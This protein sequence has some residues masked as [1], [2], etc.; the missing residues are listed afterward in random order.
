MIKKP[1]VAFA[2]LSCAG[3]S[4]HAHLIA[5]SMGY[6]YV[7]GSALLASLAGVASGRSSWR[8]NQSAIAAIRQ[9]DGA[10]QLVDETIRRRV[11]DGPPAVFDSWAL[12][13]LHDGRTRLITVL[14]KSSIRARG[15]RLRLELSRSSP[16][17]TQEEAEA[18]LVRKDAETAE[19]LNRIY[20]IDILDPPEDRFTICQDTSQLVSAP[21][22]EA[23][24]SS[25]SIVHRLLLTAI[26][27]EIQSL[28]EDETS[29]SIE[30]LAGCVVLNDAGR[31]LLL[32]RRT[33]ARTQWELPGGRVQPGETSAAAAERKLGQEAGLDVVVVRRLGETIFREGA[34]TY[35]YTWF[36][37]VLRHGAPQL[38]EDIFDGLQYFAHTELD[39][40]RTQGDLS[41]NAE[42]LISA[43]SIGDVDLGWTSEP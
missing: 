42:H 36:L 43:V 39:A 7:S 19:R 8:A 11:E 25:I 38:R 29:A 16:A 27:S 20:K 14:L 22:L 23:A 4:T 28:I 41:V 3:K 21:T 9:D 12:P 10:D 26:D 30:S 6:D 17:L 32:H 1:S 35:H 18:E 31:L 15:I 5:D 2:G 40:M 33:Q 24:A 37:G 34:V 13:F